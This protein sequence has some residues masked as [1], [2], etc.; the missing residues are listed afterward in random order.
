MIEAKSEA[1]IG[2]AASFVLVMTSDEGYEWQTSFSIPVGQ[3]NHRAPTGP[4]GY[5]YYAYDNSDTDY[6]LAAPIYDWVT[7]SP[8]YGGAGTPLLLT[9][10]TL[11]TVDL[12][13][14]FVYYGQSYDQMVVSDNGW[15][16][17]DTAHYHDFYN[18]AMPNPYGNA[19]QISPFWDNLDPDREIDESTAADGIFFF[20][21]AVNHR[22]LVEW[23]RL[24]NV[25]TEHDDLQTFQLV[26]YDPAHPDSSLVT[27]TGD[28][29]VEVQYRQIV[30]DDY[31]RMFAT[32]G[33]ED[34]SE[35]IGLQYTYANLYAEG[36]APLS[37]G[38]V[39]R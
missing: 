16:S 3:I 12:P 8:T 33:I 19:A 5:G 35:A 2:Q 28:G 37:A 21:D 38:L 25:R 29:I 6:P 4:D 10:N 7:C 18:W 31:A 39:I 17:F 11:V 1:A 20:H 36:A 23:S 30:N 27:P 14:T 34:D 15:V 24:P 32:V 22:V 26:L 13:F 9:D